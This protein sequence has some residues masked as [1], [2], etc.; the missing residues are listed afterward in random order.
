MKRNLIAIVAITISLIGSSLQTTHSEES[1]AVREITSQTL[2]AVSTYFLMIDRFENGDPGN[3][4]GVFG[5]SRLRGGLD[6]SDISFFHGGDFI[7]ITKRLDYIK[8][9]GFNAI[10]ITP[11]VKNVS[12]GF[13]AAAYHG[14]A[15][16]DFTTVDSRFGTMFDFKSLV[17]AAHQRGM[18]VFVDVVVNHTADI[19]QPQ[20][21]DT[22]YEEKSYSPYRDS[23]GRPFR[24]T[25]KMALG[26]S[27]FPKL[28]IKKSFPKVP[29]ASPAEE[30]TKRPGFLRDLTNYHNRGD[31]TFQ[32]ESV[33]FGDFYGLDDLFTEKPEVVQ[34]WIATWSRWI[35]E[36]DIDGMRIDTYKHVNDEFWH[37]FIP[38]I[39]RVARNVGKEEFPIFGEVYDADPASL[40]YY[41]R[42]VSAPS[43]LDFGFQNRVERF[44]SNGVGAMELA[45]LFNDD[46]FYTTDRFTARGLATFLGNH[47]M[48][49]VGLFIKKRNPLAT[50]Q[51]LMQRVELAMAMLFLLR[52]SPVGYYGDEKGL[53]GDP[54]DK[55]ARQDLF[56]TRV[57]RWQVE[58]RIG[59]KPIGIGSSFDS[60]HPL[61]SSIAQLQA[62]ARATSGFRIANQRTRFA[63]QGTFVVSRSSGD[64][65]FWIAF[66]ASD[67]EVSVEFEP[68][69]LGDSRVLLGRGRLVGGSLILPPRSFLVASS[70]TTGRA[71]AEGDLE[72]VELNSGFGPIGTREFGVEFTSQK[73]ALFSFYL[74]AK[75]KG[76]WSGWRF[77]GSADRPTFKTTNTPGDLYRIF[78]SKKA[79]RGK[80]QVIAVA[81][82]QD[83]VTVRTNLLTLDASR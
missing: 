52:G 42:E 25:S 1:L 30:N 18:K 16:V 60:T 14:Y 77:L 27:P 4:G 76:G 19:I 64:Q 51:E 17:E 70:P 13:G 49:R 75:V 58:E 15:G 79:W 65:E 32:G 47:D 33:E 21:G 24:I 62:F 3:D 63:R 26:A 23:R 34:G 38:A 9:L 56:A 22:S 61:E 67:D 10:W 82:G 71:M 40:A 78:V 2:D 69:S 12:G 81:Q 5:D 74:R 11:P 66:N 59:S 68:A 45:Q 39:Q 50:D 20:D 83:G 53:V 73:N 35:T 8:S 48:G 31:S 36:F 7:G 44:V 43:L 55:G 37:Q 80:A 46:D 6:P 72:L 29:V 57:T 54:G 28:D 41:I